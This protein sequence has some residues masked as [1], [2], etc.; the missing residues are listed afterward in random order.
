MSSACCSIPPVIDQT[1]YK[2][3]GTYE[4]VGHFEKAY[5]T[6]PSDA[7]TVLLGIYDIFGYFNQ[8]LQGADILADK[9]YRVVLPDFFRG[10]PFPLEKFPP[11]NDKDKKEL[12]DFFATIASPSAR[13]PELLNLSNELRQKH[14]KLGLVGYCWGAAIALNASTQDIKLFDAVAVLHPAMLDAGVVEKVKTPIGFFPSKDEDGAEVDKVIKILSSNEFKEKNAYHHFKSEKSIHGFAAARSN[15]QDEEAKEIYKEAYEPFGAGNIPSYANVEGKA[16]RHGKLFYLAKA[17]GGLLA[18]VTR[19]KFSS[20]DIKRVYFGNW[21]RDYSQAFDTAA[22]SKVDKQTIL[23]VVMVLSFLAF[24]YATDEFEV[25]EERIGVYLPTEHIDNPKGYAEG[26]DARRYDRRLRPPV[27]PHELDIDPHTGMKNYIA[28]ERVCETST[29]LV[30]RRIRE[31]IEYGRRYKSSKN[32]SDE[33][34]ALRLLGCA[35]HTLEDFPAHSNF[36]EVYLYKLGHRNVFPHVGDNVRIRAPNGEHVP[37]IVTGSF[38]GMDFMA[39]VLGEAGDHLSSASVNDLNDEVKRATAKSREGPGGGG[40]SAIDNLR[41]LIFQ[42]DGYTSKLPKSRS[43]GGGNGS[44]SLNRDFEDLSHLRSSSRAPEQMS[45]QELHA[46]LWKILSFR[47][48]ISKTIEATID[49][50]PG[51]NALVEKIS[52]SV[53]VFIYSTL[54]PFMAPLVMQAKETIGKGSKEILTRQD[55]L[56]VYNDPN[57]SDPTHSGLSKDHF[58]HL[59]NN[60]CGNLARIILVHSTKLIVE[61]WGN[62]DNP[63]RIVDDILQCIHH[64]YFADEGRSKIQAEMGEFMRKWVKAQGP[65]IDQIEHGLSKESCRKQSNKVHSHVHTVNDPTLEGQ[66]GVNALTSGGLWGLDN[67]NARQDDT[68]K[69]SIM[70]SMANLGLGGN[71]KSDIDSRPPPSP[72]HSRP[73]QSQASHSPYQSHA[74]SH[75]PPSHSPYQ[76]HQS[77]ASSH[78]PYQSHTPSHAPPSHSPYQSHSG[79]PGFPMADVAGGYGRQVSKPPTPPGRHTPYRPYPETASIPSPG[80]GGPGPGPGGYAP[81]MP[82]GMP[83]AQMPGTGYGSGPGPGMYSPPPPMQSPYGG[84]PQQPPYGG[85]HGYPGNHG[86]YP[87]GGWH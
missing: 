47:D 8:T 20:L 48:R 52:N 61:A 86:G 3:K 16:F 76:S 74:P 29:A 14:S 71:K 28:N 66:Q 26:E 62:N 54:E 17:G 59:L 44:G 18:A 19:S 38:G 43:L 6:G 55:Q 35:M 21:L 57:C 49:K 81:P 56:E 32:S 9:G 2:P 46:T 78:S 84:Y 1:N 25:T 23:N 13:I 4:K 34:E 36:A 50:I 64:P 75:A 51:L 33:H 7:H 87:G 12:G 22:L 82:Y 39:S 77:H 79:G 30:R 63:D 42:L 69:S 80:F 15:L 40:N 53:A 5:V 45:P 60:P 10:K 68:G 24:G 73:P 41:D 72:M 67:T 27:D 11:S 37:P 70:D 83:S 58:D 85:H 31:C 65:K